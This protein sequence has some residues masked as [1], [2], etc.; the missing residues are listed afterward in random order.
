MNSN[1]DVI[2]QNF[3]VGCPFSNN[4]RA[5]CLGKQEQNRV[6]KYS[7]LKNWENGNTFNDILHRESTK[8]FPCGATKCRGSVVF[9]NEMIRKSRSEPRPKEELLPLAVQFINEYYASL[10]RSQSQT[11]MDRLQEVKRDIEATN[12]YK[13][14]E[15]ELIYGAKQSWRNASRCIGRIQ[16]A[17]LKVFDARN[18]KTVQEMFDHICTHIKYAVNDGNIRSGVT[19][20]P[21]RTDGKT[22]FRIWNSQFFRY[23]GFTQ[24][25]GTVLGDPGSVDITEQCLKHGWNPT[26]GRFVMLPLLLQA[27][28]EHPVV[29][30]IPKELIMEVPIRHPTKNFL[31]DMDLKWHV[32]PTAASMLLEIGGLEF[33]AAPFNGWYLTTEIAVRNLCDHQRYN[34]LQ[35]FAERLGLDTRLSPSL[36]KDIAAVEMNIAVLHSFQSANVTIMDHHTATESF[37]K[38]MENEYRVR[39]GCPADWVWIVPPL[40]GSLT[41]VFHQEMINYIITPCYFYQPDAWKEMYSSSNKKKIH[42]KE[43][44][45]AARFVVKLSSRAMARRVKVTIL[46][47]TET[48]KSENYAKTICKIFKRAFDPKVICMD[49]YDS[50]KLKEE[51]LLLIITST[52]GNGDAPENGEKFAKLLS[53]MSR[54]HPKALQQ[55]KFSVFGLGSRAYPNFCAF[56][57]FIDKHLEALG[58]KRIMKMVEG[59]ELC[60]QEESF[61]TWAR[62]V[63]KAACSTFCVVNSNEDNADDDIFEAEHHWQPGK[64]RLTITANSLDH[65]TTLSQLHKRKVFSSTVLSRENLQSEKSSRSTILVRLDT[66]GQ[67]ELQY[68]PGDHLGVYPTNRKELVQEL[69]ARLTDAP[70]IYETIIMEFLEEK[71]SANGPVTRWVPDSKLPPCNIFQA[72]SQFLD[73]T[74]PPTPQ[75][76]QM[77]ASQA[78]D[79]REKARLEVLSQGT[80]EYE[81]WKWYSSPTIP[82]VLQEFPSVRVPTS[83]LLLSLPLLQPRYYSISSSPDAHPSEV[84]L[85]VGVLSYHTQNGKGPLHYGV[86]STWLNSINPKETV[87]C[88]VRRA[89]TFHLPSDPSEPCILIGPG[90]GIAPFRSFW[91]QRLYDMEHKGVKPLG[92]TLVFGCRQ[93]DKDHIYKEETLEAKEKGVFK[94]IYTGYSREPG[95][96]KTYVQHI[97]RDKLSKDVFQTL[98]SKKGHMYVCGDVT[99]A[100][101]VMCVVQKVLVSQGGLS[102][103]EAE[104][105]LSLLKKEKRYHEDIFGLVLHSQEVRTRIHSQSYSEEE[106][107]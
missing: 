23:A 50:C 11:H 104:E 39:G 31:D 43:M 59:D 22:D 88:F 38:H 16:W 89:P 76:L 36:W 103:S 17:K 79:P 91:Q 90:T 34:L 61:R 52:F 73:I 97:L 53:E 25:D 75:L 67:K 74:S 101:D 48:G 6:P 77:L 46:Y 47:A 57:H 15:D 60:G 18:C 80:Q 65:I 12:T 24:P 93:S 69:L 107:R 3:P 10:K 44:A 94:E 64:C 4:F 100:R 5:E 32:L 68:L 71:K 41:P 105:L 81:E 1:G 56:A 37:M 55:Q 54:T 9:P 83:L 28:G 14:T 63:F 62:K 106:D 95:I 40:S 33:P 20:F 87:P 51:T 78:T 96:P 98:H 99:M 29:F 2:L 8:D 84:H 19:I 30:E 72:F 70:L 13:L 49:E 92:M 86:C 58:A 35:E 45:N 82:E 7:R 102:Y 27:R 26:P 85:T 42:F 21:Q 66:G